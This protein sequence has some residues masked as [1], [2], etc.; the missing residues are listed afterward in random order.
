MYSSTFTVNQSTERSLQLAVQSNAVGLNQ[1]V[2]EQQ[3]KGLFRR[4]KTWVRRRFRAKRRHQ[5]NG[6]TFEKQN[7]HLNCEGTQLS[8]IFSEVQ[9]KIFQNCVCFALILSQILHSKFNAFSDFTSLLLLSSNC[10]SLL[11]LFQKQ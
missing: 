9:S 2:N 1:Q 6:P 10:A 11:N 7:N 5:T 4:L 3:P 8:P